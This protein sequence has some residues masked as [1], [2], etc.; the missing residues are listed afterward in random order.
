MEC[1]DESVPICPCSTSTTAQQN[2]S[3]QWLS[4][5]RPRPQA[6]P[7]PLLCAG[8]LAWCLFGATVC[9]SQ[10]VRNLALKPPRFLKG[11]GKKS[12]NIT[13]CPSSAFCAA[14]FRRTLVLLSLGAAALI[15][16]RM[17]RAALLASSHEALSEG[18]LG[19]G[20]V[21]AR[22]RPDGAPRSSL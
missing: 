4:N 9:L 5:T 15:A 16:A 18:W 8:R 3:R 7:Q 21:A 22:L 14:A 6:A 19:W 11:I 1:A 12:C 2:R 17:P 13:A 10:S 20:V